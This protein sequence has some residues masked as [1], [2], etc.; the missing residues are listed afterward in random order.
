MRVCVCART[1]MP[2]SRLSVIFHLVADFDAD[3]AA[4]G[5][6]HQLACVAVVPVLVAELPTGLSERA[7]LLV[8]I[9]LVLETATRQG[10]ALEAPVISNRKR[11]RRE[12]EKREGGR[13]RERVR[14]RRR[15]RKRERESGREKEGERKRER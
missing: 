5:A 11:K 2:W 1:R 3:A 8:Q 15:K 7:Q 10:R 4:S 6:V 14:E 9:L 12:K 13:K